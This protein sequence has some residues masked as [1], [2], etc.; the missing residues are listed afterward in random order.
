MLIDADRP[1]GAGSRGLPSKPRGAVAPS[2]AMAGSRGGS[3]GGRLAPSRSGGVVE[4]A[5]RA[6]GAAA[7]APG[8]A[9]A[10][11]GAGSAAAAASAASDSGRVDT[12]P[13]VHVEPP[14][15]DE[16]EAGSG[17]ASLDSS[18]L[19]SGEEGMLNI[20][21]GRAGAMRKEKQPQGIALKPQ[22][23]PT[24]HFTPMSAIG[25]F[26]TDFLNRN[27]SIPYSEPAQE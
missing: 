4:A 22:E 23:Q 2:A 17:L 27:L 12:A 9:D 14:P 3:G 7:G 1:H 5:C 13:Q 16:L 25:S 26:G 24:E 10:A 19:P 20:W 8:A 18:C 21:G 6:A 15:R 11:A